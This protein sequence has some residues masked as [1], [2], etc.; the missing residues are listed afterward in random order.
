MK[1]L[2]SVKEIF[3]GIEKSFPGKQQGGVSLKR[4]TRDGNNSLL[5]AAPL[6]RNEPLA[7]RPR[8]FFRP[9][10]SVKFFRAQIPQLH[11]RL[12]QTQFFMMRLVRDFRCPVIP[13]L[14]A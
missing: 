3:I 7:L 11:R 9:H 2:E 6:S 10:R 14:R 8:H 5:F 1:V 4:G 12:A 13:D